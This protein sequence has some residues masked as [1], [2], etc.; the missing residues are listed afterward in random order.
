[1]ECIAVPTKEQWEQIAIDF[2]KNANFPHCI[3]AVDGK[4]IRLIKPAESG[5]MYYNYKHFFS[6]VLM[7][8]A[9]CNYRFIYVDIGSYGKD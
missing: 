2:E 3:G 5:S 9:D 7:A 1:M 4:H 8:I 6:V